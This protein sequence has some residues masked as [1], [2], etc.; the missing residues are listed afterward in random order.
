M[1]IQEMHN[2]FNV[3]LDKVASAA[4][5]SFT[6]TEI[7]ILLNDAQSE[8]ITKIVTGNNTRQKGIEGDQK[9]I[10]DLRRIIT[11]QILTPSLTPPVYITVSDSLKVFDLPANY[12][13]YVTSMA[14]F[15]YNFCTKNQFVNSSQTVLAPIEERY[16]T[17]YQQDDIGRIKSNPLAQPDPRNPA[18]YFIE[19]FF[20]V[21]I[22]LALLEDIKMT[23]IRKPA[24]M[25]LILGVDC[26]LSESIQ[27]QIV[28]NA[29]LIAIESTQNER[30]N[31]FKQ[32]EAN[33]E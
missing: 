21:D 29:I 1:T 8:L 20:V 24:L 10:D 2:L 9:R 17:V 7:D 14:R 19:D 28:D 5:P 18:A 27:D 31:S 4:T 12:L 3:K 26:E 11:A 30:Y 15:R 16:V 32:E 13:H 25:N 23:Y 22:G 6:T 33:N